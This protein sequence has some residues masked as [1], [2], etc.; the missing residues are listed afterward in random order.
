MK[1]VILLFLM[2]QLTVIACCGCG[3]KSNVL[4]PV[5]DKKTNKY[6]YINQ[7]GNVIIQCQY[8]NC[9][10]FI[11]GNAIVSKDGKWG[12]INRS[13]DMIVP[14]EYESINMI[15]DKGIYQV[16]LNEKYGLV[17]EKGAVL[18]PLQFSKIEAYSGNIAW[19]KEKGELY[20]YEIDTQRT[21]KISNDLNIRAVSYIKD[22]LFA[23][24]CGKMINNLLWKHTPLLWSQKWGII[25]ISGNIILEE[26]Y[27]LIIG[28]AEN[29]AM[30]YIADK[31]RD[32]ETAYLLN[33]KGEVIKKFPKMQMTGYSSDGVAVLVNVETGREDA[34]IDK[35]GNWIFEPS[36][37][38]GT[39]CIQGNL[40]CEK[41]NLGTIYYNS[42]GEKLFETDMDRTEY[43]N[44]YIVFQDE[45]EGS[46]LMNLSGDIVTRFPEGLEAVL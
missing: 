1:K 20:I 26:K 23:Y 32:I 37:I 6:G 45:K 22:N 19:I 40:L 15:S 35:E 12:V 31:N 41:R 16:L 2:I 13:G 38:R 28:Y 3:G 39:L 44:G 21:R 43:M 10:G 46:G 14:L 34:A 17:N 11:N 33:E 30:A 5:M 7:K 9:A 36:K 27:D 24:T 25:D 29:R 42:D 4:F 8:D 18:V